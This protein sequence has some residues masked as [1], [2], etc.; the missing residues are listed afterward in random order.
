MEGGAGAHHNIRDARIE[1]AQA[2]SSILAEA[3]SDDPVMTWMFGGSGP[4]QRLFDELTRDVYLAHGFGHISDN[5]AAA[6]WLPPGG[7]VRL[8][9][10]NE[11]RLAASVLRNGGVSALKRAK[12][13]AQVVQSNHPQEP[14]YYLFAVGVLPAYQGKGFGGRII[15]AGLARADRDGA[16]AYLENSKPRNTPLYERLGFQPI[17]FLGLPSGAPPLLG[18][19]RPAGGS[20]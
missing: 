19:L 20:A 9:F 5:A 7:K 8:P 13:T 15:R 2:V 18:M 17:D 10:M 16:S 4:I 14:H 12:A 1:D 3:F 11:L 6:L